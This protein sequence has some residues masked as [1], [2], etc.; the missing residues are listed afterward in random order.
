[1]KKSALWLRCQIFIFP[2]FPDASPLT[3]VDESLSSLNH[4]A[5]GL[6][7]L[8]IQNGQNDRRMHLIILKLIKW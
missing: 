7:L 6:S 1:M 8:V 2:Q 3:A 5:C 4:G